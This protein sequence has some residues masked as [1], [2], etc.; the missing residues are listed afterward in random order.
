[1]LVREEIPVYS[2]EHNNHNDFKKKSK[3]EITFYFKAP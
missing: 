2:S 1:M 3:Y